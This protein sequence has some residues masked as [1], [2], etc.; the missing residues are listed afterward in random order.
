MVELSQ[1]ALLVKLVVLSVCFITD[2]MA[3]STGCSDVCE[4]NAWGKE[5][6]CQGRDLT[7][8]PQECKSAK[9][10]QMQDNRLQHLTEGSFSNF[11]NLKYLYLDRNNLTL[12]NGAFEGCTELQQIHL[13]EIGI[14]TLKPDMMRGLPNVLHMFINKAGLEVIQPGAFQNMTNLQYL[15]LQENELMTA[16]CDAFSTVNSL[17]TLFLDSNKITYL[18]DDCFSR[19]SHL[20]KLYLKNNPLGDLSGRAFS[21][22]GNLVH[23]DLQYTD[24]TRVPTGIFPYA[25]KIETL[26]LS[27]NDIQHLH[28]RDF[29]SL[30]GLRKLYLQHNQIISIQSDSFEFLGSLNVLDISF[31]VIKSIETEALDNFPHLTKL[32]LQYNSLNSTRNITFSNIPQVAHLNI[33]HNPLHCDCSIYPL[34]YWLDGA[35]AMTSDAGSSYLASCSTPESLNGQFLT[36]LSH[37][38]ICPSVKPVPLVTDLITPAALLKKKDAPTSTGSLDSKMIG[39]ITGVAVLIIFII[40]GIIIL[41]MKIRH[42]RDEIDIGD[43]YER[44]GQLGVKPPAHGPPAPAGAMYI[45]ENLLE[46]GPELPPRRTDVFPNGSRCPGSSVTSGTQLL[47]CP[48]PSIGDVDGPEGTMGSV[49]YISPLANGERT[50]PSLSPQSSLSTSSPEEYGEYSVVFPEEQPSVENEEAPSAAEWLNK[51]FNPSPGADTT[52]ESKS[53]G[54]TPAAESKNDTGYILWRPS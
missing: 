47:Q 39:I 6:G 1:Q 35:T 50:R 36:K 25:N 23:L 44:G 3:V 28:N 31:N 17:H 26:Q 18:P 11:S 53:K 7:Y 9:T 32:R 46:K 13:N 22:L 10:L 15:S 43:Q 29:A 54:Q 41:V 27:F 24:L 5:A 21:G 12:E 2:C 37:H 52:M 4:Y 30:S 42:D 16:P 49:G 40:G 33:S 14:P 51:N 48:Y 8:V 34:Q 45:T 20:T 38:D 19:F